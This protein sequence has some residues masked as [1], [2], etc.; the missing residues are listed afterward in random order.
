[1]RH[2][3][4]V[5]GVMAAAI[6]LIVSAAMNWKFGYTL[7]K[8]EFESQLYGGASAAAD[9]FKALLPFFIFAALRNRS[10]SQALGGALL[11]V[12]CFSYSLS[13]S[14]GF[15]ALNRADTTSQRVLKVETHA[16]LRSDLERARTALTALPEHRPSGTVAGEIEAFKQNGR[17]I[18]SGEC[19]NATATKSM[20][21]CESYF[22]LKAELAVAEQADKLDAKVTQLRTELG[23]LTSDAATKASDPQSQMLAG[24]TGYKTE[25]VQ[26]ALTVLIALLVE[27]GASLG[28]YTAFSYWRIFDVKG[29]PAS[30]PVRVAMPVPAFAPAQRLPA[31]A[32]EEDIDL[33]PAQPKT[34]AE[35]YFDERVGRENG[36]S[37]TALALYDDY[38]QWCEAKGKQPLGLPI[39]TRRFSD[40]GVQKAKVA[41]R[42]RYMDVRLLFSTN[43]DDGLREL[44]AVS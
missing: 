20:T 32:F 33:K 28:F 41:G 36:S 19:A 21:Y 1:M 37:V 35:L 44:S 34:D 4:G 23:D 30:E 27:L 9:C 17:W 15:A 38:C 26:T 12:V 18:S 11:F 29:L 40:L 31:L 6:L 10:Y 14:L 7:G 16:D 22:K 2:V 5:A 3:L 39:F 13:S 8:S 43:D 25:D 42:I 24:L